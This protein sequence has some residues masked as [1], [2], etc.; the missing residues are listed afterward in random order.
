LVLSWDG[1][2]LTKINSTK[3]GGRVELFTQVPSLYIL[4]GDE[5]LSSSLAGFIHGA[6]A[7]MVDG[8]G[9][10]FFLKQP[11][12]FNLVLRRRCLEELQGHKAFEWSVLDLIDHHHPASTRFFGDLSVRYDFSNHQYLLLS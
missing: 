6:D 11:G 4:H 12:F 2:S 1:P 10:V 9:S 8:Y 7:G 3:K 5:A